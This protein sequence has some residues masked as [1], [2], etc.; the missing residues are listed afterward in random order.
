MIAG[1]VHDGHEFAVQ[2][3][4]CIQYNP[5][6]LFSVSSVGTDRTDANGEGVLLQRYCRKAKL[7]D[8]DIAFHVNSWTFPMALG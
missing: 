8:P 1:R 3:R 4:R 5:E 6:M 2:I 7:R